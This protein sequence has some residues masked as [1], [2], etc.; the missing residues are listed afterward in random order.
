M[1]KKFWRNLFKP[2]NK[3]FSE[4]VYTQKFEQ[5]SGQ[6]VFETPKK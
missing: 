3:K 2:P 1:F 4:K 6:K 5:K